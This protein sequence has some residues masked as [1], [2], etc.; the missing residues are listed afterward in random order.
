MRKTLISF[1]SLALLLG[2][3]TAWA[4]EPDPNNKMQL[5]VQSAILTL[6][7]KDPGMADWFNNAAGY[8]VFPNVGKGAV[9]IGGAHGNG[10]VIA[11]DK[12]VG[13][14]SLSQVSIG[15]SLGGQK[16]AEFIFFKDDIALGEFKRGN[17]EMGA[18]ASAVIVKAGASA[19]AAYNSGVA[20]FTDIAGGV[21][22]DV[23]VGGQKF[24]YE[25]IE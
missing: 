23:S 21:M 9:G 13:K 18:Q 17:Y 20:I 14:T 16:Y 3:S 5:E 6:K 15:L 4:W 25:A 7:S 24:S 8:A 12:V 2:L 11:G 1:I 19:D 22:A 10:L